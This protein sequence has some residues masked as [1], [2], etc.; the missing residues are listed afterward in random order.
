M[1]EDTVTSEKE[2]NLFSRVFGPLMITIGISG[3]ILGFALSTQGGYAESGLTL[4][5]VTID[6]VIILL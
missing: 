1:P 5:D 2:R 6:L 3:I 4:L